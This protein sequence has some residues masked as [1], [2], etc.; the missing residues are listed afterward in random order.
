M[1]KGWKRAISGLLFAVLFFGCCFLTAVGDAR[2]EEWTEKR[3]NGDAAEEILLFISHPDERGGQEEAGARLHL[4]DA[5]GRILDVWESAGKPKEIKVEPEK[6]YRIVEEIPAPGKTPRPPEVIVPPKE[7]E[8]LVVQPAVTEEGA[9]GREGKPGD[10]PGYSAASVPGEETRI[11][12]LGFIT[13]EYK[14]GLS[15]LGRIRIGR[16]LPGSE[17][18]VFSSSDIGTGDSFP[19]ELLLSASLVSLAGLLL[20]FLGE[21]R[22]KRK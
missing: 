4:E 15:G 5:R 14:R 17:E 7:K 6:P 18:W 16:H 21:L 9:G 1:N 10:S 19:C 13:L 2:A 20:L 11:F 22:G 12:R 8:Y 3:V